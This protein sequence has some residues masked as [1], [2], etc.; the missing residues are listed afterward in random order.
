MCSLSGRNCV[1]KCKSYKFCDSLS[2][3]TCQIS[4]SLI[5]GN[6]KINTQNFKYYPNLVRKSL[7]KLLVF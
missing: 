3:D 4:V 1:F 7:V 5:L 6:L 2:Y